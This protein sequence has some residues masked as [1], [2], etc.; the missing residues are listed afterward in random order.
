MEIKY[1]EKYEWNTHTK[2]CK[3]YY[4]IDTEE[5]NRINKVIVENNM[6]LADIYKNIK[7]CTI[8]AS[9]LDRNSKDGYV[10]TIKNVCNNKI[11]IGRTI[12][13]I[14]RIYDHIFS[15]ENN[16]LKDDMIIYGL[17]NF[18]C[19]IEYVE[20]YKDKEKDMIRNTDNNILY[21]VLTYNK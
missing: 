21:N 7:Q 1:T 8:K 4:S 15:Q 11:Y 6:C 3:T 19:K 2:K 9:N 16:N 14:G 17:Q 18:Y 10:Y 13:P 5:V 12:N 20:E